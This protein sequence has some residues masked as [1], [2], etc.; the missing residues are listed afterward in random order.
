MAAAGIPPAGP[1]RPLHP[2]CS[3][4]FLPFVYQFVRPTQFPL[5][6][7]FLVA[8]LFKLKRICVGSEG[9]RGVQQKS[10]VTGGIISEALRAEALQL[11]WDIS[12]SSDH[13]AKYFAPLFLL[14]LA[15]FETRSE[16]CPKVFF[17]VARYGEE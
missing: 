5:P 2:S 15:N 4:L 8:L 10:P 7:Y 16:C 13:R 11:K 17:D 12:H 3:P 9:R 14:C 6:P 1:L